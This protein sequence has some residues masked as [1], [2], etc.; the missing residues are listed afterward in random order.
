VYRGA[1]LKRGER[2]LAYRLRLQADDRT[3]KEAEIASVR[4]Q[5]LGAA[6]KLGA[7]LRG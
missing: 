2:S 7:A 3:L 4:A 1:G 5:L 6:N